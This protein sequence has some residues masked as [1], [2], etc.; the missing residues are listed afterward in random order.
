MPYLPLKDGVSLF[1]KDWGNATGEP[2]FFSHG[3]PLNSDNWELQMNFL[4]NQGY[5][6][7]AH[8]RRGHGR[9][10]Q[11]WS[12][13]NID[14][15]ADDIS[16]L[17]EHLNLTD[18]TLVGHSTGG[19]DL[20]RFTAR[21]KASSGYGAYGS[22]KTSWSPKG[23]SSAST[24]PNATVSQGL[25]QS[26]YNQGMQASFKSVFDTVKSWETDF[27]PDLESLDI[28][29]LVIHGDD[30]QIVPFAAGGNETIKYLKNGKLK[31][32]PGGPHA[33]PNIEADGINNDLLGFLKEA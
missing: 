4:G 11:P 3:W 1:Y 26:W 20:T 32:Y 31:V 29:V 10:D 9:S 28:P 30:D 19:G 5:R 23:H 25:I 18:A 24:A 2:V 33:L 13:N 15:W 12:G 6:V 22:K 27:R 21:S 7:I 8:D 16:Q 17:F 14:T